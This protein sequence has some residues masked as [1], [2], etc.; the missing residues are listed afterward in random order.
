MARK[1]KQTQK[2]GWATGYDGRDY[3]VGDR[4]E[5][6]PGTD[7]WMRGARYGT[8]VGMSITP[9]DRVKVELDKLPGR[10]Y[11][12]SGDTFKL[13]ESKTGGNPRS[14]KLKRMRNNPKR[15]R[16]KDCKVEFK[17][18]SRRKHAARSKKSSWSKWTKYA[19]PALGIGAAWFFLKGR[20]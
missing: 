3:T 15:P 19:L 4:V 20:A 1:I 2:D 10:K 5:I 13:I 6:H 17:Y 8:V 12:G 7:M 9:N 11:S 14:V 16:Y 18:R